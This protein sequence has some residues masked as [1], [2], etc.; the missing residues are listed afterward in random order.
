MLNLLIIE[1]DENLLELLC[2]LFAKKGYNVAG[3]RTYVEAKEYLH[4][5]HAASTNIVLA[6]F[7]LKGTTTEGLLELAKEK[8]PGTRIIIMSADTAAM[9]KNMGTLF[10]RKMIDAV[11]A[12]PC[13]FDVLLNLVQELSSF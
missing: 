11:I 1:D 9:R 2:I 4:G 13:D 6:D 12:K 3:K 8:A 10:S 7:L 5:G